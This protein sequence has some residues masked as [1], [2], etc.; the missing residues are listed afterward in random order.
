[1]FC[2]LPR[3]VINLNTRK[4]L[5]KS[6]LWN[7]KSLKKHQAIKSFS[8][9]TYGFFNEIHLEFTSSFVRSHIFEVVS[10]ILLIKMSQ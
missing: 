10:K 5:A 6:I 8:T 4:I 2:N 1:M 9:Q 7:M 3:Y